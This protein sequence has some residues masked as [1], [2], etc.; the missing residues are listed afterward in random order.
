MIGDFVDRGYNSVE[1]ISLLFCYKLKYPD[2]ITLLRGNHECRNITLTYGFY[3]EISKKYG[4]CSVWKMFNEAFDYL[5]IAAIVEGKVFC[6]HGG[7]S[8]EFK[9]VDQIRKLDRR[10]EIP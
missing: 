6:V 2:R 1:T 10:M 4:N 9:T 5:P 7:L 8:P 3:D